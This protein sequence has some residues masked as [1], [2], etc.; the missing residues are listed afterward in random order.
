M[1][2][3]ISSFPLP[4]RGLAIHNSCCALGISLIIRTLFMH[5]ILLHPIFVYC[6]NV[7][8]RS[9]GMADPPRADRGCCNAHADGGWRPHGTQRCCA[10]KDVN[11]NWVLGGGVY[12]DGKQKSGVPYHNGKNWF[13]LFPACSP[14]TIL[15][16]V[17]LLLIMMVGS[18][19]L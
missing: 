12:Y 3:L 13:R 1:S 7:V 11:N 15:L 6:S 2:L 19:L 16:F 5:P 10:S 18:V 14:R 9:Y 8:P 17:F 4:F